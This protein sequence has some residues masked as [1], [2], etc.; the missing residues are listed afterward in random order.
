MASN[1]RVYTRRPSAFID[2]PAAAHSTGDLV[3][4]GGKMGIVVETDVTSGSLPGTSP[5]LNP[6]TELAEYCVVDLPVPA[7]TTAGT[8]LYAP[9]SSF[10]NGTLLQAALQRNSA[11]ASTLAVAGPS[12]ALTVG[13]ATTGG[14]VTDGV[15]KWAYT[16]VT[17]GS[18]S[19]PS[20]VATATV[21]STSQTVPLS[22]IAAGPAGTTAR[23]IYRTTAG[24]STLMLLHTL[25]DNTT[26]T[27]TDTTADGSLGA[28]ISNTTNGLLVGVVRDDAVTAGASTFAPVELAPY[29]L[30]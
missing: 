4:E 13:T 29:P 8:K 2:S 9:G 1:I 12:A 26:T 22:A 19:A 17:G 11:V 21:S 5:S 16:F 18:E 15:H 25:S 27:Y 30:S 24:G 20:P 14:S 28:A 7:G 3:I 23:N 6:R 10:P